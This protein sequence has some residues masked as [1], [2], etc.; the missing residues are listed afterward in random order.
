M[1]K[2]M[3]ADSMA[4]V[5]SREWCLE[6]VEEFGRV[7]GLRGCRLVCDL[8]R[9]SGLRVYEASTRFSTKGLFEEDDDGAAG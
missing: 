5:A 1:K 3:V 4:C 8:W 2:G 7:L 6:G 9:G